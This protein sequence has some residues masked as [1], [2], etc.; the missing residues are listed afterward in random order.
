MVVGLLLA[1]GLQSG[2]PHVT[3]IFFSVSCFLGG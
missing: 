3:P 2:V 1:V